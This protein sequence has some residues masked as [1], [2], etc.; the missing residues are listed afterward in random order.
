MALGEDYLA[1]EEDGCEGV[2]KHVAQL[3]AAMQAL[4]GLPSDAGEG[5][6]AATGHALDL[7]D[8][9]KGL[10]A[11]APDSGSDPMNVPPASKDAELARTPL[12]GDWSPPGA[13]GG[14]ATGA[15]LLTAAPR[16]GA[17]DGAMTNGMAPALAGFPAPRTQDLFHS[18]ASGSRRFPGKPGRRRRVLAG[19][20]PQHERGTRSCQP[21]RPGRKNAAGSRPAGAGPA[22]ACGPAA[23]RR[24][25]GGDR[26][27]G[28][29][30]RG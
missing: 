30:R 16:A 12:D 28:P 13:A 18:A 21:R 10:T 15:N 26:R 4:G 24:P 5:I 8:S 11:A 19:N 29:R 27:R 17:L 23:S 20:Q 3:R 9:L 2:A 22:T 6:A 7:L 14:L 25:P 1:L